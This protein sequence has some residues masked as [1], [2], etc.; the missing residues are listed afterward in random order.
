M[1]LN[2][3]IHR[4]RPDLIDW[5]SLDK[6]NKKQNLQYAFDVAQNHLGKF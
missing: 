2:A 4:H 6:K 5:D 1:A 3:L